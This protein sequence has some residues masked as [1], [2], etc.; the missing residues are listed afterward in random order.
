[1]KTLIIG[2]GGREHAL[3]WKMAQSENVKK[4]FVA[5][6][7]GGTA[8]EEKT[9][10]LSLADSTSEEGQKA[11]L[12]FA[13]KEGIDITVV[14][15]EV[16][17]EAGLADKFRAAGLA[18]VGPEKKAAQLETSK[19]YAKAFMQKYGVRTAKSKNFSDFGDAY[20][21]AEKLS[22]PLVIKADGLA[23]GKGVVIASDYGQAKQALKEF[24]K[25]GVLGEAGKK[26]VIEEYIEGREVSVLAAVSTVSGECVIKPFLPARDHKRRFE[27]GT[28][29]N[30]GGM[31]AIAPVPDFT[32]VL[33]IDFSENILKPTIKGIKDE[34]MNYRGFIFF[35]VMMK[36]D[37]CYLLE[38]NVRL[39]DPETQSLLPLMKSDFSELC[40]AIADGSLADFS[41][42]WKSGAVCA[43]VAASDGYPG[44]YRTGM[45]IAINRTMFDKTGAKLF[46]SGA[47]RGGGGHLGSGLRTSGGRVLTV[48]ALGKDADDSFAKAYQALRFVDFEG[49]VYRKDI[50]H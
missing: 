12:E 21:Y 19:A 47:Q 17:L 20:S 5:P 36:E 27:G 3:A 39:G 42:D 33:Q 37:S 40:K 41:I 18:I 9:E 13:L 30:T 26:V 1:M 50:G 46:A 49:M 4:V 34:K 10:N 45:P 11:L 48:S 24:M 43:P 15:P 23:S 29:P 38:Y 7:N 35:G 16:P 14:G 6:G 44:T 8:G 32:K 2:S 31:G 28:G 22:L 25:D